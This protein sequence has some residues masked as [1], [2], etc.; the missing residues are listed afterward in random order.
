MVAK[1]IPTVDEIIDVV[2]DHFD[3]PVEVIKSKHVRTSQVTYA[4]HIAQYLARSLTYR[5]HQY[6]ATQFDQL[7]GA[8]AWY[9][10]NRIALLVANDEKVRNTVKELRVKL[11]HG[12]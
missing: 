7:Q 4:R 3:V 9:A 10:F 6:I 1:K 5:S 12:G 11:G 2:S 8:S